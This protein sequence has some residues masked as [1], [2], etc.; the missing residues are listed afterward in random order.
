MDSILGWLALHPGVWVPIVTGIIGYLLPSPLQKN[1]EV[2]PTVQANEKAA[3]G[4]EPD[5][6]EL[7]KLP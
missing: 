4:P 2:I 6:T 1:T 3:D 5:M 7:D